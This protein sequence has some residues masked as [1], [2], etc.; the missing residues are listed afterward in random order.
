MSPSHLHTC[1]PSGLLLCFFW[2]FLKITDIL[3]RPPCTPFCPLSLFNMFSCLIFSNCFSLLY[4]VFIYLFIPLKM[5]VFFQDW[6]FVLFTAVSAVPKFIRCLVNISER[7]NNELINQFIHPAD[8]SWG[9]FS[10]H[11]GVW[12]GGKEGKGHSRQRPCH[13]PGQDI[14]MNS[15]SLGDSKHTVLLLWNGWSDVN[16]SG[17]LI[18]LL[19]KFYPVFKPSNRT[20]LGPPLT[21]RVLP[22]QLHC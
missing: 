11:E 21:L 3:P 14:R 19:S 8:E 18:F 7:A 2:V 10:K 22:L 9:G 13:L 5:T 16:G 17:S 20:S 12:L 15:W 4:I 1:A 6:G